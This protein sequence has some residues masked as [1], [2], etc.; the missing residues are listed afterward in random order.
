MGQ[1]TCLPGLYHESIFN[2]ADHFP[3]THQIFTTLSLGDN[4]CLD[5]LASFLKA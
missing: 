2:A 1:K 4:S 3:L 5:P